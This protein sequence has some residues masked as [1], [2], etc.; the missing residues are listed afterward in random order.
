MNRR[1]S[2]LIRVA[3]ATT[4]AAVLA[5]TLVSCGA[6]TQVQDLSSDAQNNSQSQNQGESEANGQTQNNAN[7]QP[8]APVSAFPC[9][10]PAPSAAAP[11]QEQWDRYKAVIYSANTQPMSSKACDPLQ[12]I[13]AASGCCGPLQKDDALV[14]WGNWLYQPDPGWTD[15][16]NPA[17]LAAWRGCFYAQYFPQN[18]LIE[19]Y[20]VNGVNRVTSVIFD[21][22]IITV[23]F[24][25][26]TASLCP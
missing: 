4:F 11:T 23:L 25:A 24:A 5:T 20:N 16:I 14:Q 3:T 18:A 2:R 15:Q 17:D 7:Q 21:G 10:S 1:L 12:Y 13:I 26:E 22:D 6:P 8:P 19:Q 9:T